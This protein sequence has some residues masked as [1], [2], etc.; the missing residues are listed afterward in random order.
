MA[1]M[2]FF[3][4]KKKKVLIVDDDPNLRVL[5]RAVVE[6]HDLEALEAEDGERGVEKAES[7][8]PA[9][10]I[11]DLMMPGISG[12]DAIRRIRLNPK[13][14]ETPI[15]ILSAKNTL[16]DV[17]EGLEAGANTYIQKP[18]D[19]TTLWEKIKPLLGV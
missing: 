2:L 3:G 4:K 11:M 6:L 12:C 8:R 7:E 13:T 19:L 10:V 15:V 9:L 18:V 1:A 17:D 14:K 16:A 5:L